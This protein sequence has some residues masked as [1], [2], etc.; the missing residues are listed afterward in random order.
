[1]LPV[2]IALEGQ[3]DTCATLWGVAAGFGNAP[4]PMLPVVEPRF[5]NLPN[6]ILPDQRWMRS[7]PTVDPHPA[8]PNSS[9][10]ATTPNAVSHA[11]AGIGSKRKEIGHA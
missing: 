10:W 3:G 9:E 5:K 11:V 7:D 4:Q 6:M 2:G 8:A 1:M